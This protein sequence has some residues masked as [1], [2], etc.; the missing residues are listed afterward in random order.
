MAGLAEA[1]ATEDLPIETLV[2]E[3]EIPLHAGEAASL[4]FAFDALW[5]CRGGSELIR[6]DPE[7]NEV[8]EIVLPD[9]SFRQRGVASGEGAIWVADAGKSVVFKIDPETNTVIDEFAVPMLS[10]QGQFDVGFGSVWVVTSEN[11]EKML[12]RLDASNGAI[13]AKIALPF[14]GGGVIVGYGSVWVTA[15]SGN[16]LYASTRRPMTSSRRSNL[17]N[18]PS[19]WQWGAAPYGS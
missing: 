13:E 3:T 2:R 8:D 6:V 9:A 15:M 7:T 5:A 12:T 18:H 17:G 16:E 10:V 4:E 19:S 11:F 14:G 1:L